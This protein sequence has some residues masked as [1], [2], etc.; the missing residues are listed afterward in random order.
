MSYPG[1]GWTS[2]PCFLTDWTF[3]KDIAE[4]CDLL[5]EIDLNIFGKK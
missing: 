5:S 2:E 3:Q 4:F 1:D